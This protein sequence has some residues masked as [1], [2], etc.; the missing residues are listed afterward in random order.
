MRIRVE[1]IWTVP[2][3]L[4]ICKLHNWRQQLAPRTTAHPPSLPVTD[5][6]NV[7]FLRIVTLDIDVVMAKPGI[8]FHYLASHRSMSGGQLIKRVLTYNPVSNSKLGHDRPYG[9]SGRTPH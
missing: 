1:T 3:R 5:Y 2:F 9:L 8:N 7:I 4:H 6:I